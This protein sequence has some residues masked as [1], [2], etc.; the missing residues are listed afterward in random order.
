MLLCFGISFD[1]TDCSV[2]YECIC[3][4]V[5]MAAEQIQRHEWFPQWDASSW[6]GIAAIM[7]TPHSVWMHNERNFVCDYQKQHDFS[8][9]L[10]GGSVAL[11]ESLHN[12]ANRIRQH[13]IESIDSSKFSGVDNN[14]GGAEVLLATIFACVL[15]LRSGW[16]RI[17]RLPQSK[18]ILCHET[19][20]LS[21]SSNK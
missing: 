21:I 18:C 3:A 1:A 15:I 10:L 12:F 19:H 17:V 2:L 5:T 8:A 11:L 4:Y 9:G 13:L 16:R 14:F 6:N 20:V 7:K